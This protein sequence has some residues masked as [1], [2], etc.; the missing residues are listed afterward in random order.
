MHDSF[1]NQIYNVTPEV[2]IYAITNSLIELTGVNK[3]QISVNG[4]TSVNYRENINLS[5]VFERNLDM[6]K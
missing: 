6:V 2:T 5:T 3:V 1:L 4:E